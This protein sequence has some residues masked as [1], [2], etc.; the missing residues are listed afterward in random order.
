[1]TAYRELEARFGQLGSVSEA[2]VM[3]SPPGT[4]AFERHLRQRYLG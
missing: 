4:A 1:M 3:L 2:V